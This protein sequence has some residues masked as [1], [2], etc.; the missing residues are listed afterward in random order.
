MLQLPAADFSTWFEICVVLSI[1]KWYKVISAVLFLSCTL[2]IWWPLWLLS[3]YLVLGVPTLLSQAYQAGFHLLSQAYW[4]GFHWIFCWWKGR[5]NRGCLFFDSLIVNISFHPDVP[6]PKSVNV[7]S[8]LVEVLRF[9]RTNIALYLTI[10]CL[11]NFELK[12]RESLQIKH[13]P[14]GGHFVTLASNHPLTST[15]RVL[16]FLLYL[17]YYLQSETGGF[18]WGSW[19]KQKRRHC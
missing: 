16:I 4:A 15:I 6:S 14:G 13:S 9:T 11:P 8:S 19:D 12:E 10:F 1:N 5:L 7:S 3:C 17:C 2:Q 18:Q